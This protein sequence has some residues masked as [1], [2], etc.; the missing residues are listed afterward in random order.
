MVDE[1]AHIEQAANDIINGASFDNNVPCIAEKEV[2]VVE[3]VADQL[4]YHMKKNGAYEITDMSTLDSLV[5]K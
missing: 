2:F 1:T 4:V 3:E 5:K